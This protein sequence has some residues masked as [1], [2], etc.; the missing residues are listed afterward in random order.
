[1][2]NSWWYIY[3]KWNLYISEESNDVDGEYSKQGY[4][5]KFLEVTVKLTCIHKECE[6]RK[7]I[8]T[9]AGIVVKLGM[10]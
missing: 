3:E 1:M 4:W 8:Y 6:G 5:I 10:N 9:Y 7:I 2:D